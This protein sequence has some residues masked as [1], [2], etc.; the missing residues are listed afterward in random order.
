MM[1]NCIC[2]FESFMQLLSRAKIIKLPIMKVTE[3]MSLKFRLCSI[4]DLN[5]HVTHHFSANYAIVK[6]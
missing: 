1:F 6:S 2:S 5:L 3:I 4:S